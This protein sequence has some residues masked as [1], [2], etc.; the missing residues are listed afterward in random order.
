MILILSEDG[1]NVTN[2]VIDWLQFKKIQFIRIN[3][4]EFDFLKL[5]LNNSKTN[6]FN[7][8]I[9]SINFNHIKSIWFRRTNYYSTIVLPN[10]IKNSK[11]RNYIATHL[12][13][14]KRILL[15]YIFNSN[16]DKC[17]KLGLNGDFQINKLITLKYASKLGLKIPDTII[18]N[19]SITI[20]EFNKNYNSII[21]KS[22][23]DV[24][25]HIDDKSIQYTETERIEFNDF[26][27]NNLKSNFFP[28]LFQNNIEKKIEIRSFFL[29]KKIYSMAIFTQENTDSKTD[30]RNYSLNNKNREV[31][32][33]LPINIEKKLIKLFL[34][35]NLNIGVADLI[36]SKDNKFYFLEINP[37][38]QFED[39]SN[40]GNYYLEEK[41][42]NQLIL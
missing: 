42:A 7:I 5:N 19:K 32:F 15:E 27:K 25:F 6:S 23:N 16:F 36:Y 22:I 11:L 28:S 41:I 17:K 26:D 8:E 29:E 4:V 40:I 14:E 2:L 34:K 1:D 9:N 39:I 33:L 18:A 30:S 24:F 10:N 35:L 13:S 20:K 31:P 21:T 38:G 3:E 37:N 12:I